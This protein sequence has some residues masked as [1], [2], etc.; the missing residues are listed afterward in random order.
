[1]WKRKKA[2]EKDNV[3]ADTATLAPDVHDV[4]TE[5]APKPPVDGVPGHNPKAWHGQ[6]AGA[7]STEPQTA[8]I[9]EPHPAE[10]D[11]PTV[12]MDPSY[13]RKTPDPPSIQNGGAAAPVPE[14]TG[15]D[16]LQVGRRAPPEATEPPASQDPEKNHTDEIGPP[17]KDLDPTIPMGRRRS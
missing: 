7:A 1:M 11:A 17:T 15:N 3:G 12:A 9:A 13:E 5:P 10:S 14:D 2:K 4:P 16:T 8:D 6:S